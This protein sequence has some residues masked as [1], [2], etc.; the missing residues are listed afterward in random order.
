MDVKV[1]SLWRH[2]DFM[3][4]WTGQ[5][6]SE[7]GSVVTRTAL[8]IVAVVTLHATALEMGILIASASTAVDRKSVV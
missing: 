2:G 6:V 1:V 3:K 5:T 8:P 7:L 4:L